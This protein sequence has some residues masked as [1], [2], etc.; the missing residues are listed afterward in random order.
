GTARQAYGFPTAISM[1]VQAFLQSPHFLYRIQVGR[2][3]M[4]RPDVAQLTSYEIASRLSYFLWNTMP[5]EQL[6]QAA[7]ADRLNSL[8]ELKTQARRLLGDPRAHAAIANFHRQWLRFDKMDSID[9]TK[10]LDL[11]PAFSPAVASA[12]RDSAAKFVEHAFW[13]EG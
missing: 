8:D 5:D 3:P 11:F 12:M 2:P 9:Y 7:D 1:I 13:D 4:G 10:S 6:L